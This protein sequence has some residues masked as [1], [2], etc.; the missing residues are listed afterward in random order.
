MAIS[1][2]PDHLKRYKD[3]IVLL[4]K[5]GRKDLVDESGLYRAVREFHSNENNFDNT[6]VSGEIKELPGDLETLGPTYIK[7]GQ[8][9]STRSD[10]LPESYLN[11]LS[12][13]QD[14][15]K[16]FPFA[17]VEKIISSELGIRF[18]KAFRDF[19]PEP[20]GAASIGQVHRAVLKDGRNVV[21]KVQRPGIRDD[22]IKDL[23]ALGDIA[24]FLQN[25]TKTGEEYGI[26]TVFNEFR[27]VLIRELD[28][29]NEVQNL[30]TV[31]RNLR[32]FENIIVPAPV[33]DYCTS[34][35]ITMDYISGE[36]VTAF[37]PLRFLEVDGKKLANELF[38]A[39]LKQIIIDG[40]YHS[41]PHP[42]NIFITQ[43][44]KIALLDLGMVSYVSGN[45]QTRLLEILIALG[46]G[47]GDDVAAY[48]EEVSRQTAS[49]NKDKFR[50]SISE[51]I[52]AQK[53][54]TLE[55][56]QIGSVLLEVTH[57]CGKNG[58]RI[59]DELSMLG[60]TLLNL[61]KI[62]KTLAPDF[63][64]N[65]AIREK[66]DE[67]LKKKL[68]QEAQSKKPYEILLEAKEFFERLPERINKIFDKLAN[69]ELRFKVD[70]IDEKFLM[71]G[72]QKVANRIT[73]GL[74]I[75]AMIIGAALI[76]NIRTGFTIFGYP[77]LAILL[78]LAAAI[79]GGSLAFKI[80]YS[81][82]HSDKKS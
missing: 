74:I 38:E 66:A 47:R 50:A 57:L 75:A 63:N 81:D 13:L 43:N 65:K 36:N 56:L 6:E 15:V 59:P 51:F 42:G 48:V 80:L 55:D 41:D 68:T 14:D 45:M 62:G 22:I 49:F 20:I 21:V 29:R 37:S 5:Y 3:M 73:L 69:N 31:G 9:L 8:F 53:S 26:E 33:E 64:P 34:K 27:K 25:H 76:M 60:K 28:Y 70:T 35:V 32:E 61:D 40:I 10:L 4:M 24:E 67:L 58:L 46:D 12:R 17:E 11:A 1:L 19:D 82:V 39:Y 79:A 16:S 77:G 72:F 71:D 23:D 44:N 2:N 52:S 54:V 18:S 7:L 78:F 30:K